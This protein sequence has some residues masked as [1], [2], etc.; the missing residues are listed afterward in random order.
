MEDSSESPRRNRAR[1]RHERRKNKPPSAATVNTSRQLRP[2]GGFKLPEIHIP[3]N[4]LII[5]AMA[6]AAFII[7]VI[8]LIGRFKNESPQTGANA[9]WLG[10]QYTY[11][12]P[13]DAAVTALI[14]RLREHNVG[15]VYAWVGLLQPNNAWTDVNKLNQVEAFAKQF[16][17]L[18][19]EAKLYGWLSIGSQG[20]DGNNRLGDETV[21]QLITDFSQRVVG[22]L[23]FDGVALNVVPVSGGD[24]SFLSLLRKIRATI[25]E[26][27]LMA[28]A[29]PPDWTPTDANITIPRQIA[30]GTIWPEEYKQRVALLANQ[31][32]VTAYS[33]GLETAA[34]YTAW[35]AYQVQ[36]FTA[37][38][39]P[40]DS[41]TQ[42]FIGVP[43]YDAQPPL[44]DPAVE[45]V[46]SAIAGIRQGMAQVGEASRFIEGIAIYAEWQ[47]TDDDWVKISTLWN[48]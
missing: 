22:D 15:T 30:P 4:Y 1:E 45:N 10:T 16:K 34:D 47:T 33:S 31:M 9:I 25:G 5:Y 19:P 48:R 7:L 38:L 3:V 13:N 37:A 27:N 20:E 17:L 32:I 18:Y 24:E 36:S 8:F 42:I 14:Q 39:V 23:G 21:Q 40:L 12:A 11:D 44:H 41:N 29:V 28:V 35:I 26:D 46:T 43:T 6:G 2:S